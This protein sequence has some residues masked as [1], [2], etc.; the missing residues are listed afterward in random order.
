LTSAGLVDVEA[1]GRVAIGRGGGELLATW[2][3]TLQQ[4]R[5]PLVSADLVTPAEVDRMLAIYD[6]PGFACQSQIFHCAWGRRAG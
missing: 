3:L 6:D 4:L 2:Q 1:E 5:Q